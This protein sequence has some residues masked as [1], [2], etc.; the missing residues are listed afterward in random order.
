MVDSLDNLK[1]WK[2]EQRGENIHLFCPI[3]SGGVYKF[4]DFRGIYKELKLLEKFFESKYIYS[5]IFTR[6][7]HDNVMKIITKLGYKPYFINLEFNSLWFKKP[8]GG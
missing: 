4:K 2:Y 1:Y 6:L 8:L 3:L 5:L 7:T